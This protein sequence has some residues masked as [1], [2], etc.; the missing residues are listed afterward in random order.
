[1]VHKLNYFVLLGGF[2]LLVIATTQCRKQIEAT[3]VPDTTIP[4]KINGI[5][6]AAPSQEVDAS[7]MIPIAGINANWISLMP[8]AF[9]DPGEP[10]LG[11]DYDF[12]WWGERDEGIIA[13]TDFARQKNLKVLLKPHVWF[14]H[15]FYTGDFVLDTENDWQT[16]EKNYSE[17]ILH[18]ARLADSLK[19][20]M[21]C[22]GVEFKEFVAQRPEYWNLLI[23]S[24]RTI[25]DGQLVY[26]ANWDNYHTIPFWDK[27]DYIGIDAYFPLSDMQTPRPDSLLAGWEEYFQE[28]KQF[29]STYDR[30]VLF[31]E[32]GYKS[33]DYTAKQPWNPENGDVNLLAQQNAL[34]SA[35]IKFWD[36]PWFAGGFIWK[37]YHNHE[38]AGGLQN[39]DYTPQNKPVESIITEYFGKKK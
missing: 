20:P 28:L 24:L 36:E 25:Y 34:E 11:F 27:L 37:W 31:T 39:K 12:Q 30:P 26:S 17:Y 7:T 10:D 6:Y 21:Y 38:S 18:F 13:C 23:D 3:P 19:I 29:S 32:V 2:L 35:F 33:I 4:V 9:G 8:F 15:G 1:M 22:I 5:S 14:R 16:F